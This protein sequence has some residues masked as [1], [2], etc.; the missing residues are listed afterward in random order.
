MV[1]VVFICCTFVAKI[2]CQIRSCD[3]TNYLNGGQHD[4]DYQLFT[5]IVK[6]LTKI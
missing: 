3:L 4:P 6:N 5:Q 2:K 1:G